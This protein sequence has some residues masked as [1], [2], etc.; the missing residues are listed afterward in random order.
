MRYSAE[1]LSQIYDILEE[2]PKPLAVLDF[3]CGELGWELFVAQALGGRFFDR[4]KGKS[5]V[6]ALCW[7]GGSVLYENVSDDQI[8]FVDIKKSMKGNRRHDAGGKIRWLREIGHVSRIQEIG[9]FAH[10]GP[11]DVSAKG[12]Y[13]VHGWQDKDV[14][15]NVA[16]RLARTRFVFRSSAPRLIEKPY[17]AI[18]DRN[19]RHHSRRNTKLWQINLFHRWAQKYNLELWS[20]FWLQRCGAWQMD[21]AATGICSQACK[22]PGLPL[23]WHVG[24]A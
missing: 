21:T 8:E 20:D 18:F 19:D 16:R 13:R 17:I 5:R 11:T 24:Q 7:L 1:S 4:N 15:R 9:I 14:F 3:M 2:M 10:L 6:V 23:V 22:K 12:M